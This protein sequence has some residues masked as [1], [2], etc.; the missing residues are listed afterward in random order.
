MAILIR[1]LQ[2]DLNQ[3]V[4]TCCDIKIPSSSQDM[5]CS[6]TIYIPLETQTDYYNPVYEMQADVWELRFREKLL[7]K[8]ISHS[9]MLNR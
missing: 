1:V 3:T 6:D 5:K 8:R 4:I 7:Q 2:H 9:G